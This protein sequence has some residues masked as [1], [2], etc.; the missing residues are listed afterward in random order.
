MRSANI[1][2]LDAVKIRQCTVVSIQSRSVRG[3]LIRSTVT[4][5]NRVPAW[6]S[7]AKTVAN[8]PVAAPSEGLLRTA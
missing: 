5:T 1:K 2:R 6:S 3:A 4:M 7:T 8:R